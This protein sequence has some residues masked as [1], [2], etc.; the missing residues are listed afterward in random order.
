MISGYWHCHCTA[1]KG[2]GIS[3]LMLRGSEVCW[4]LRRAAPYDVH[5]QSN[6]DILVGTR[7]DCYDRYCIRIEEMR[8]S[9]RIIVQCLNQIP[10]GM[11]KADDRKLCP[12]SRSRMKLSMESC[13]LFLSIAGQMTTESSVY[14]TSIHHSE[15]YTEGF[16][17]PA[18]STYTVVEAPK[19]EFGVFLVSNGSNHPHHHKN[20][21]TWLCP[22]TRTRFYV[23]TSHASGCGH[24]HRYSRYCVWRG[25]QI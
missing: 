3:G 22:F 24:H 1:S 18:S 15:P 25:R 13:K 4:D 6:P 10:S 20:K 5:D 19:R 12:P 14:S 16:F 7:G 11:I 8:Q 21:S 9:V 2:F 23:Q 17:V